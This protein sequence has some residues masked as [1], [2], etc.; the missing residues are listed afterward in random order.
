MLMVQYATDEI[1]GK[2]VMIDS[3]FMGVMEM[4]MALVLVLVLT[5]MKYHE[6]RN[7]GYK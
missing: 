3:A 6:V 7:Y 4:N 5:R 1:R 2:G